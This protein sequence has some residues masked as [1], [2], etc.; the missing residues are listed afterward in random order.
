M[1][2]FTYTIPNVSPIQI[3]GAPLPAVD[4]NTGSGFPLAGP[5]PSY[6]IETEL[7][8]KGN[9]YLGQKF[10]ITI[11]GTTLVD[12]S[13][14]MLVKGER[15]AAVA[16]KVTEIISLTYGN[17]K[18]IGPR[19]GSLV[20]TDRGGINPI[21]FT[22]AILISVEA[23]EQT[24]ESQGVQDQSYVFTF[25]SNNFSCKDENGNPISTL[26]SLY[27]PSVD[28][29]TGGAVDRS[30]QPDSRYIIDYSEDWSLTPNE[31]V[32][33]IKDPFKKE[34]LEPRQDLDPDKAE[35]SPSNVFKTWTLTH[36]ISATGIPFNSPLDNSEE[37]QDAI[38]YGNNAAGFRWAKRFIDA[39][40]RTMG[41]DPLDN[42]TTVW[43]EGEGTDGQGNSL[44]F[45]KPET[46][47]SAP[48][49][50][51]PGDK[52][53]GENSSNL[54][55]EAYTYKTSEKA[56]N[57]KAFNQVNQFQRG[58]T[59]GTY[60]VTRTWQIANMFG[61]KTPAKMEVDF[62]LDGGI[63]GSSVNTIGVNISVEGWSEPNDG[64]NAAVGSIDESVNLGEMGLDTKYKHAWNWVNK[65]VLALPLPRK[66]PSSPESFIPPGP[67]IAEPK[68]YATDLIYE[69]ARRYYEDV[70]GSRPQSPQE[71]N[72]RIVE[73]NIP[74]WRRD[75]KAIQLQ[76]IPLTFSRTD[77]ETAGTITIS[78]S[79]NDQEPLFKGATSADVSVDMGNEDGSIQGIAIKPVIG[80]E[81]GPVIQDMKITPERTRSVTL[82]LVMDRY[83]RYVVPDGFIW[84]DKYWKPLLGK[85]T[86][87]PNAGKDIP[88]YIRSR[89][90]N[91]NPI[92]G[93]YSASVEYV[94]TEF[95]PLPFEDNE[96]PEKYEP[97][98]N[99][100]GVNP[101]G[102]GT[103]RR[104]D[105]GPVE[106]A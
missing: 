58:V 14:S 12:P 103:I 84:I 21:T 70:V 62:T 18:D 94:W 88:V 92:T 50:N 45:R 27:K 74:D 34:G 82:N 7:L 3:S 61:F 47:T 75:N 101:D 38:G 1:T 31:D 73:A 5:L 41:N 55:K 99:K 49:N 19:A 89:N 87:G 10:I 72:V 6:T 20:I 53:L 35:E 43:G 83:Y 37:P 51:D 46:I 11:T 66:A 36:N 32:K 22:D 54:P 15:Q 29:T 71:G 97:Q 16:E 93:Q 98:S 23:S 39:R 80:K 91:W 86:K 24:E 104:V 81:D 102:A 63:A 13:K 56:S 105:Q 76:P 68:T 90:Q 64:D 2:S 57:F 96:K 30:L 28:S 78:T 60:S 40:L 65:Y 42:T 77:N 26:D 79:F 69:W 44:R 67:E 33:T 85:Y 8:R 25:E 9:L 59:E 100:T 48:I 52:I 17:N 95:N 4:P 106:Q